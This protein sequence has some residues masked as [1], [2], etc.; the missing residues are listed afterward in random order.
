MAI[1]VAACHFD[2]VEATRF[3][4]EVD[5]DCPDGT[6]CGGD[7]LCGEPGQESDGG[8]SDD[9]GSSSV[10]PCSIWSDDIEP[11]VPDAEDELATELGV[12]V[13]V[14]VDGVVTAIRYY[15]ALLNTGVH[16]GHV[17][18]EEGDVLATVQFD[19]ESAEGWQEAELVQPLAVEA[20]VPF[21]VSYFAPDGHYAYIEN[22]FGSDIV[23]G[24]VRA[25]ADEPGAH[26]GIFIYDVAGGFPDD[27]NELA[28]YWVDLV[29]DDAPP[30]SA[31]SARAR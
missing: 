12:R 24:P 7:G 28:N 9:D 13:R 29:F 8:G 6:E 4:C 21:I 30:S 26:N 14:D 5:R 3:K 11:P 20:G 27:T 25:L 1:T 2:P 18:S 17:W 15:K 23:S 22:Y 10:C 31:V 16:I 19:D